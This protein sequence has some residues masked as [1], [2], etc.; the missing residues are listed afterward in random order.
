MTV[1]FLAGS[2][3]DFLKGEMGKY[4]RLPQLVD[5]AAQVG[6]CIPRPPTSPSKGTGCPSTSLG[7]RGCR[8]SGGGVLCSLTW[9]GLGAA[10][11]AGCSAQSWV[12]VRDHHF[13]RSRCCWL[14]LASKPASAWVFLSNQLLP[15]PGLG[16]A[17]EPFPLAVL[18]APWGPSCYPA[19]LGAPCPGPHRSRLAWP[20]WRG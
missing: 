3:L 9:L 2:L 15:H 10:V 1:V 7:C 16:P 5:M 8:L 19:S 14:S 13:A 4:L 20:T 17:V 12:A 18:G 6:L 11:P